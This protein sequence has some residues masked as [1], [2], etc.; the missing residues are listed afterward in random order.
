MET[1]A[2]PPSPTLGGTAERT[3]LDREAAANEMELLKKTVLRASIH[4][5]EATVRRSQGFLRTAEALGRARAILAD[6]MPSLSESDFID[7]LYDELPSSSLLRHHMKSFTRGDARRLAHLNELIEHGC[8][9]SRRTATQDAKQVY[10]EI[11]SEPLLLLA[12]PLDGLLRA[13]KAAVT[14]SLRT[15]RFVT[16]FLSS[17]ETELFA[18]SSSSPEEVATGTQANGMGTSVT[19]PCAINL[20]SCQPISSR[21]ASNG[22]RMLMEH[23]SIQEKNPGDGPNS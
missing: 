12:L 16:L 15:H 3:G 5:Q 23:R 11:T 9:V 21:L 10:D 20:N 8:S 2:L 13:V 17:C 6:S 14:P 7:Y 1:A 19:P 4:F 18:L 22:V